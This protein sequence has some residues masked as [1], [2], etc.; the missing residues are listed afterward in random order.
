MK[1]FLFITITLGFLLSNNAFGEWTPTQWETP[2]KKFREFGFDPEIIAALAGEGQ[3]VL[4]TRPRAIE[5]WTRKKGTPVRYEGARIAYA[6]TV[7]DAPVQKVRLLIRDMTGSDYMPI[8]TKPKVLSRQNNHT[9]LKY[10]Q[11]IDVPV[12]KLKQKFIFQHTELENG[13]IAGLLHYGDVDAMVTHYEFFPLKKNTQTLM[14]MAVWQDLDTAGFA[15]RMMLNS[16]PAFKKVLIP[17]SAATYAE[18]FKAAATETKMTSE[19]KKTDDYPESPPHIDYLS[20]R[21]DLKLATLREM[22]EL[23]IVQFFHKRQFLNY[24]KKNITMP[25][26]TALSLIQFPIKRVKPFFSD[27]TSYKSFHPLFRGYENKNDSACEYSIIKMGLNIGP[28]SVPVESPIREIWLKDN[29]KTFTGTKDG[30]IA[31][32]ICGTEFL[33]G[34]T[35]Q[36]TLVAI[37]FGGQIGDKA[38]FI[39]RL[40][41]GVPMADLMI[42]GGFTMLT[43]DHAAEYIHS[44][45]KENEAPVLKAMIQ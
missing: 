5:L 28:I 40:L 43:A 33:P 6:A 16:E 10:T 27:L 34:A 1:Q 32:L 18:Q 13:D 42:A 7:I 21:K 37:T 29:I 30:H 19:L 39:F 23:G 38:P 17:M 20:D 4:T 36:T 22:T 26:V 8:I 25:R 3:L 2:V 11:V 9:M 35:P 41:R 24:N 12:I 14:I 44:T 45:F 31:P 15:F